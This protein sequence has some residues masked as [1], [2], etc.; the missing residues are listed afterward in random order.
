MNILITGA[1]GLVGSNLTKKLSKE[2]RVFALIRNS[3]D[4]RF[5]KNVTIIEA[6]L[7][8]LN[9]SVLPH[10]IDT[11]YYLAQSRKFR[12]F[13]DGAA[14][15]FEINIYSALKIIDWAVKNNV[16]KF[17]YA[18]TGGVYKNPKTP[19]KEFFDINANTASGFYL[20]S[21]LCAEI[22]LK[23]YSSYFETF[24][25]LR[26]FFIY[27]PGQNQTMLIPRLIKNIYSGKEIS[28]NGKNGIK[29]NPI[30]VDDAAAAF[31]KLLGLK[32]EFI[33][34]LAGGEVVSIKQIAEIIGGIIGK[35][36][37]F[38][39][40]PPKQPDLIADISFMKKKLYIP[41]ITLKEGIRKT[42]K[43]LLK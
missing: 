33:F 6:D 41:K 15:I 11:V 14:D 27:G 36:P 10:K 42:C 22:L 2:H 8:N 29:T 4:I 40:T 31:E 20:G 12:D 13:P 25:I 16:K 32:G 9:L 43:N 30:Y 39:P 5:N 28:L 18:S 23:N 21:K 1:T 7:F 3:A 26:P 35:K 34:N 24:A 17:F 19:V 38:K 37:Y